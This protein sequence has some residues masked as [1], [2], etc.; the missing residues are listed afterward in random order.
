MQ[1]FSHSFTFSHFLVNVVLNILNDVYTLS[2][3][4]KIIVR[5]G[6]QNSL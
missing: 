2:H 1:V 6:E 4:C 5:F 3:L